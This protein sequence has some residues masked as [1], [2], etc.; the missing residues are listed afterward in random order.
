[1][2]LNAIQIVWINGDTIGAQ[3]DIRISLGRFQE[4][5]RMDQDCLVCRE[6]GKV[7]LFENISTT[8]FIKAHVFLTSVFNLQ[9]NLSSD[10]TK[11]FTLFL[12]FF[13]L[14]QLLRDYFSCRSH[15]IACFR[16]LVFFTDFNWS[17]VGWVQLARLKD[18]GTFWIFFLLRE[19]LSLLN[20]R[21]V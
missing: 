13:R 15:D 21:I 4:L 9:V 6:L 16:F 20:L 12:K 5:H 1:M 14:D 19:L 8:V 17:I 7:I 3:N 18:Y 2:I 10:F 11:T